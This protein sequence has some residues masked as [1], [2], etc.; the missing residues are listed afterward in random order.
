LN[1]ATV[2]AALNKS[3]LVGGLGAKP[4]VLERAAES[5]VEGTKNAIKAIPGAETILNLGTGD[6]EEKPKTPTEKPAKPPIPESLFEKLAPMFKPGI[7]ALPSLS[8]L[9]V[10][11]YIVGELYAS[12]KDALGL[13]D[14]SFISGSD[15]GSGVDESPMFV[16]SAK[17]P[18]DVTV[19]TADAG[20]SAERIA[21]KETVNVTPNE[22]K[23]TA[24]IE[25]K[26]ELTAAAPEAKGFWSSIKSKTQG[27]L[28]DAR[29]VVGFVK[30]KAEAVYGATKTGVENTILATATLETA[31]IDTVVEASQ[32]TGSEIVKA[33]DYVVD[34]LVEK[35]NQVFETA[36]ELGLSIG[37]FEFGLKQGLTGNSPVKLKHDHSG[38]DTVGD[39]TY[40]E[41]HEARNTGYK[42]GD[43]VHDRA[44][45]FVGI[46]SASITAGPGVE[47]GLEIG[48]F[49]AKAGAVVGYK[50]GMNDGSFF[51]K[52]EGKVSAGVK[53][54]SYEVKPSVSLSEDLLENHGTEVNLDP[55]IKV[56]PL[57]ISKDLA[58]AVGVSGHLGFI[59]GEFK[60]KLYEAAD[61]I[62]GF[63][64]IDL[65]NDDNE[66]AVFGGNLPYRDYLIQDS[67][68]P[69]SASVPEK[70]S[71]VMGLVITAWDGTTGV[72]SNVLEGTKTIATAT[73][74]LASQTINQT[75]SATQNLAVGV[76]QTGVTAKNTTIKAT[77]KGLAWSGSVIN[78]AAMTFGTAS[79]EAYQA[80]KKY[81][82]AGAVGTVA[83]GRA[84]I[85]VHQSWDEVVDIHQSFVAG[86]RIPELPI[87]GYTR[88]TDPVRVKAIAGQSG[89]GVFVSNQASLPGDPM[90]AVFEIR[91]SY[92]TPP[93]IGVLP[94]SLSLKMNGRET[95]QDVNVMFNVP[96]TDFIKGLQNSKSFNLF[97]HGYN[98]P[99]DK[100][101]E[102][103]NRFRGLFKNK[104]QYTNISALVSWSGDVG[105]N[106]VSKLAYFNRAVTSARISA[107]GVV[108]IDKYIKDINPDIKLN[109]ATH[110]LGVM[111]SLEAAAAGVKFNNVVLLVPAIER[112]AFSP[113]G[114]YEKAIQN[115]EH[116]VVIYSRKQFPVFE[117]YRTARFASAMG[118]VGPA[119]N[120]N[121]PDFRAIDATEASL[122]KEGIVIHGHSDIYR[123]ETIKFIVDLYKR[124]Q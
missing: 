71:K 106:P 108:E 102:L 47:G 14:F 119:G 64:G 74:D 78:T 116:L 1:P 112:D 25:G 15:D 29:T 28:D 30:E 80:V 12:A 42:M 109:G 103:L 110:S 86:G 38:R 96:P 27:Y 121:H 11:G 44:K 105:T 72:V 75:L 37:N 33:K 55:G 26:T 7:P 65:M 113:G 31:V 69:V 57:K 99:S 13:W 10:Q 59:G 45:D 16:A 104:E 6:K 66:T 83:V 79:V 124:N 60:V 97:F 54:G 117:T 24:V 39:P 115:I 52:A 4:G 101:L 3:E 58:L 21:V 9:K 123:E 34:Q 122:N 35:G 111:P 67:G 88:V 82:V 32:A 98:V 87:P 43:F 40:E 17:M 22:P 56:G 100:S 63:V 18:P 51:L 114:K 84:I 120:V 90:S 76:V 49:K 89:F 36:N 20:K 48:S 46:F 118:D 5:A 92:W 70:P 62:T 68:K 95:A 94:H 81:T 2:R 19:N 91:H 93:V 50:M 61:F 23:P 85:V 107:P 41:Y 8:P 53:A 73:K 77:N